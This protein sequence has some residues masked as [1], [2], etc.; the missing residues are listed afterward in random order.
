MRF[1][2]KEFIIGILAMLSVVTVLQ[3]LT[4]TLVGVDIST[5]PTWLAPYWETFV[6][7]LETTKLA[8]ICGFGWSLF[9]FL[10]YYYGDE[11]VDFEVGKMVET[12]LW[13]EGMLLIF[14]AGLP[15]EYAMALSTAIMAIK[16]VLNQAM[17]KKE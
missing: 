10:R 12:W 16:S 4:P 11:S 17:E 3:A 8:V 15:K 7:F 2:V 5:L 6:H 14:V 9:G 13:F 1:G